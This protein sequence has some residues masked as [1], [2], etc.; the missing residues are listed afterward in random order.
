MPTPTMH[1]ARL[2]IVLQRVVNG[3]SLLKCDSCEGGDMLTSCIKCNATGWVTTI[4]RVAPV[5]ATEVRVSPE[6]YQSL[7]DSLRAHNLGPLATYGFFDVTV[8][9][10][11]G[12]YSNPYPYGKPFHVRLVKS[13]YFQQQLDDAQAFARCE[14]HYL[15]APE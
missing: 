2:N 8:Q 5:N 7:H 9:P 3:E 11:G 13:N 4:P 1:I 6:I 15:E 14:A 12:M 10:Y